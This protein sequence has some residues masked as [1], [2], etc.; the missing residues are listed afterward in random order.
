MAEEKI[1][2][3]PGVVLEHRIPAGVWES[4]ELRPPF[5]PATASRI[6]DEEMGG[7]IGYAD[8]GAKGVW[9]IYNAL[10]EKVAIEETPLEASPI[11]PYDVLILGGALLKVGR[12]GWLARKGAVSR[13]SAAAASTS[14]IVRRFAVLLRAKLLA[15]QVGRIKFLRTAALHMGESGRYVPVYILEAVVKFGVRRPDPQG[16]KGFFM[17][18]SEITKLTKKTVVINKHPE[19]FYVPKKY[20]IEVLVREADW[21]ISHFKYW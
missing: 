19:V 13:A 20:N 11:D 8:E 7:C 5:V 4:F 12:L 10:G 18:T 6:M 1:T 15:R 2:A 21:A 9:H 16:A 3:D 14:T 17:Y